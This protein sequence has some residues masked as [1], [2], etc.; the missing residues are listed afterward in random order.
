MIFDRPGTHSSKRFGA[1]E[2]A[3]TRHNIAC[4]ENSFTGSLTRV[5]FHRKVSTE[6]STSSILPESVKQHNFHSQHC[7][8]SCLEIPP[9]SLDEEVPAVLACVL[10]AGALDFVPQAGDD[11]L[12]LVVRVQAGD[13]PGRQQIVD[14]HQE[15]LLGHLGVRQEEHGADV[16]Q[17]GFG[18]QH[19]Q[20]QLQ[21]RG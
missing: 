20:V 2:Q 11:V 10:Q 13:L 1:M 15:V 9:H 3:Y 14:Q 12:D 17:A 19:G 16:L 21:N 5:T 6:R 7:A 4:I 8:F 18:A